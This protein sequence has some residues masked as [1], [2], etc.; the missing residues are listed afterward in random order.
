[1]LQL[2]KERGQLRVAV[3]RLVRQRMLAGDGDEGDAHQGVGAGGEHGQ[4]RG[5]AFH[6]EVDLQT[7]AAAQPVA[8][9][10]L[11]RVGPARQRVQAV[12]Q[13]LRVVGDLQEP[14]RDLALLDHRAGAPAAA[15]DH[16]LVGQH[17][18]VDR[19]PVHHRVLA[20]RQALLQQPGEH[21]LFPAVVLRAAG[22]EL[23]APVDRVAQRLQL[24]AH[25]L[26]VGV[27]PLR[28]CG[29]VLDRG[30]LRRQA[31]RVPAHRLQH[32][33]ALHALVAA[34][35]V[36]DGV[37]AHV[38]HVQRAGR[39]RQHGEAVELRPRR[40]LLHRVGALR[41]PVALRGGFHRLRAIG[42]FILVGGGRGLNVLHGSV[43]VVRAGAGRRSEL[44]RLAQR[45]PGAKLAGLQP[46]G[47]TAARPPPSVR[48]TPAICAASRAIAR[49]WPCTNAA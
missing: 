20:V 24:A 26:D 42:G 3:R 46:L 7:L 48:A 33:L 4:R 18:V 27:G 8:L 36:A 49:W 34:D 11:H 15:V 21:Q 12:Q 17:G 43:A 31:E 40:V 45:R 14:L 47:Q 16:L 44:V 32:V 35:H 1:M 10:G 28:R 23:A 25:V 29:G 5:L 39:V 30:V 19:V 38:A 13:L 37:V 6:R 22:G 9:H 41:V 2:V